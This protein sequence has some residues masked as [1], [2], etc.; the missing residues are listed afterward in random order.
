MPD[1]SVEAA[2][3]RRVR[4]TQQKGEETVFRL[5]GKT[6]F[7]TGAGSG[8][9]EQIA[10]LFVAQGAQVV[11]ADVDEAG[12]KRVAE[13]L[14]AAARF[15]RVDVTDSENVRAALETTAAQLGRLDILVNN[16]GI[17]FVGNVEETPEADFA[18]L[19]QVNVHGVFHCCKHAVPIMLR[20]GRGNIIN[21]AS[22]A[23]L[24]AVLRRFAYCGTKGAVIAMTRELAIDYA[25]KGIRVNA[26]APG[27]VHT[28]FVEGYLQRFHAGEI[29]ETRARLHARQP[30]GRMAEPK[31]IAALAVYLAADESE[32]VTGSILTIDGGLT[33]A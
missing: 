33:A 32:F 16:A 12:G 15:L 8:I 3:C 27:T 13:S 6:A 4:V 7:I 5:D 24:V 17:G 29:E 28:P 11:V 14:G 21:L 31:E 25:G 9:G 10:R 22:V 2:R 30:V 26:I 1:G 19:M 23:G 20:Q 18:R